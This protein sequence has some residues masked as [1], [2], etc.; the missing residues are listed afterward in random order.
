[1]HSSIHREGKEAQLKANV[2]DSMIW[3]WLKGG[4][5]GQCT[6]TLGTRTWLVPHPFVPLA[7]QEGM[8]DPASRP[9]WTGCTNKSPLTLVNPAQ[10]RPGTGGRTLVRHSFVPSWTQQVHNLI[11]EA[12]GCCHPTKAVLPRSRSE[13]WAMTVPAAAPGTRVNKS[14]CP[15][16]FCAHMWQLSSTWRQ[17]WLCLNYSTAYFRAVHK[18]PRLS[19]IMPFIIL[20]CEGREMWSPKPSCPFDLDTSTYLLLT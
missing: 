14:K 2:G 13:P 11:L 3:N 15:M 19:R 16:L 7:E 1:M 20:W 18:Q 12:V 10:H 8:T 9:S 17:P 5:M 4:V 6:D